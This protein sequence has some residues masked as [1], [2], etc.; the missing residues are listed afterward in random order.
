MT[1]GEYFALSSVAVA[2]SVHDESIRGAD[3]VL[4]GKGDAAVFFLSGF[5][6]QLPVAAVSGRLGGLGG[7]HLFTNHVRTSTISMDGSLKK[8]RDDFER[9]K[10]AK[11]RH[12]EA[13]MAAA[14][15]LNSDVLMI[16]CQ[17]EAEHAAVGCPGLQRGFV[18]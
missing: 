13:E 4:V 12:H 15:I 3:P 18:G 7:M 5:F 11:V 2:P 17:E 10:A 14:S 6:L 1:D 9:W 8:E 16:S